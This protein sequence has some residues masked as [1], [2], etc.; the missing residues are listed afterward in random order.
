MNLD[1]FCTNNINVV[2]QRIEIY[3]EKNYKQNNF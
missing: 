1:E 3:T 2:R